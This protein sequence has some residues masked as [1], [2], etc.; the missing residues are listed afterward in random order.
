HVK[1][2][3]SVETSGQAR[4]GQGKLSLFTEAPLDVLFEFYSRSFPNLEPL[5]LLRMSRT[6][7]TLRS[8]LMDKS[9]ISVWQSA[10]EGI[11]GLPP[12]IEGLSEPQYVNLMFDNHCHVCI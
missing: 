3:T 4:K 7:K 12:V 11:E 5:D 6:T 8:L 10:L 1:T 2:G 9:Y